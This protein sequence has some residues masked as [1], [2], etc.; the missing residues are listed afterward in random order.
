MRDKTLNTLNGACAAIH[1]SMALI[2]LKKKNDGYKIPIG[3]ELYE[4]RIKNIDG[5][6]E[7]KAEKVKNTFLTKDLRDLLISFFTI[8]A[9]VHTLYL[10]DPYG[11]YSAMIYDRNNYV[12]WIEY[13]VTATLMINIIARISGLKEEKAL[14]LTNLATV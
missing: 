12:R 2:W 4:M 14:I 7:N 9:S 1:G 10:T 11:I 8:T 5:K 13:S 6:I 3:N